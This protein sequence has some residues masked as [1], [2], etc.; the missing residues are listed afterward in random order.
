MGRFE[1]GDKDLRMEPTLDF[2]GIS[3]FEK[4]FDGFFEIARS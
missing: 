4:K 3:A 2:S 1:A